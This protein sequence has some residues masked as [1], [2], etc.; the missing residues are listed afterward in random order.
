MGGC[1]I[2]NLLQILVLIR[3]LEWKRLHAHTAGAQP[4]VV[5]A[6]GGGSSATR[7]HIRSAVVS[8][9]EHAPRVGTETNCVNAM[10]LRRG[11]GGSQG[12]AWAS[13]GHKATRGHIHQRKGLT[14]P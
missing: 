5:R 12:H 8:A 14:L 1:S 7:G 6:P 2:L 10:W 4:R 13:G 9:G 3:H 11:G